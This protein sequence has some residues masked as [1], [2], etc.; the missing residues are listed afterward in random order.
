MN[1]P[2]NS[3]QGQPLAVQFSDQLGAEHADIRLNN[4]ELA[5]AIE[6]AWQMHYRT[7]RM[8]QSYADIK[9]HLAALMREQRR[10]AEG[11]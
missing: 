6:Q 10:R 1:T 9:E 3:E 4:Y 11:A 7:G 8:S 2:E 5:D